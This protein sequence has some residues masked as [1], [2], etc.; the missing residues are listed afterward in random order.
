MALMLG[1]GLSNQSGAAVAALAFP[2]IGP[3]G[4]V[5]VR[6]WVAAA[7]LGAAGRPRLR[8]FTAAQWRPVLCLALVFAGMNLSL[9]AAIERI[10][11]GLAVTLEFLGPL[12]V[13]LAG[14]R[15][16]ADLA[17]ALAAAGAVAVLARPTP[18]TDY[19][20]IGLALLAA[21][22]WGCYIQCNRTVGARLPG[23]EGSAA[24]ALVSGALYL[25][26]GAWVLW[27]HPP[28]PL[29]LVCAPVAGVL[30]SA[31]PFVADL[32]ALRRVPPHFFGVFM[33]VNPVFAALIGLAVLDQ[34]LDA[35]SWS[36]VAVIVTANTVVVST[37]S[38]PGVRADAATRHGS[39]R[40]YCESDPA[41]PAKELSTDAREFLAGPEGR[42]P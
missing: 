31:V 13:A 40:S 36:A 32:M 10:G 5:A 38:R 30:S 17:A 20:G 37:A 2:A 18:T 22:C 41:C 4:V 33:S 6:Q 1:S 9:Y 39:D 24:A 34:H 3:V 8:N 28:T 25:P 35:A 19:L 11:L 12:T 21:V 27:Q 23:L 7:V 29:A 14:S 42:L 15:R 26:V 16:R